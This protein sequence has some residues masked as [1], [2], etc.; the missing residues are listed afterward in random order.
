MALRSR[1]R[2]LAPLVLCARW[3][4]CWR[5][6][7]SCRRRASGQRYLIGAKNFSEQ[8][9][10]SRLISDQLSK[11]GADSTRKAGLGSAVAFRALSQGELDVYVDYSGTIWANVHEAQRHPA[12]RRAT[13]RAQRL[14]RARAPRARSWASSA[15]RTRMRSRCGATAHERSGIRSISDLAK[16]EAAEV[17]WRLRVL[18]APGVARAGNPI[19][20]SRP[21]ERKQYQSTFMYKA[22]ADG[23]VDVISAFSSDGRVASYDLL[24]LD[25]PSTP[26]HRTTRCCSCRKRA[27][28]IHSCSRQCSR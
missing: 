12:A 13:A 14:A 4:S 19:R 1:L 2:V 6:A 22:V 9:I 16:H 10:L 7:R 8:Y 27:R 25:D 26:S 20:L 24:V 17:R 18:R 15:S 28:T 11:R 21:P 23:E 3:V 5:S